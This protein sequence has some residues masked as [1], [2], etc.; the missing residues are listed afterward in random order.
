MNKNRDSVFTNL[1]ASRAEVNE[2]TN[3]DILHI[4]VNA[5][6]D[7]NGGVVKENWRRE[8]VLP[9]YLTQRPHFADE[10]SPG[11]VLSPNPIQVVPGH[12]QL[13]GMLLLG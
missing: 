6:S 12:P 1:L 11:R 3:K 10:K 7:T 2:G 8:G 5:W 9:D 13:K 4:V